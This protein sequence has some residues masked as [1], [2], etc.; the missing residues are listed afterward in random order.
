MHQG[1]K[2]AY[3][4]LKMLHVFYVIRLIKDFSKDIIF[5]LKLQIFY[6][7]AC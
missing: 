6:I 5:L 3:T 4:S 1:N 2:T 7:E